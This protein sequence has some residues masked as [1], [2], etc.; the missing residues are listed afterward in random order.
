MSEDSTP[1]GLWKEFDSGLSKERVLKE[2]SDRG[3]HISPHASSIISRPQFTMAR[4]A[5]FK[6]AHARLEEL[7]CN[8]ARNGW[9]WNEIRSAVKKRGGFELPICSALYLRRDLREQE[10]GGI[11]VVS[12]PIVA[13]FEG[14]SSPHIFSLHCPSKDD[15][16]PGL[17]LR[18]LMLN[19]PDGWKE[20]VGP[21]G[22]IAFGIP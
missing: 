16:H 3:M 5:H 9:G 22:Q 21:M 20:R 11:F 14:H 1:F 17:W 13:S 10:Q 12:K 8:D 18:V 15:E 6:V 19:R 2:I 7:G 4:R